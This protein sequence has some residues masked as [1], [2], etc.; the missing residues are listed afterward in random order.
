MS[1][2]DVFLRAK[3]NSG[4]EIRASALLLGPTS[5]RGVCGFLQRLGCGSC[6]QHQR[7][8]RIQGTAPGSSI[9]GPSCAF[10]PWPQSKG[11][12][13]HCWRASTKT[14]AHLCCYPSKICFTPNFA[15]PPSFVSTGDFRF[16]NTLD[17]EIPPKRSG[18]PAGR[19][20]R[21]EAGRGTAA[22]GAS[23]L[24]FFVRSAREGWAT[25][26]VWRPVLGPQCHEKWSKPRL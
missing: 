14:W 7:G 1:F 15:T 19:A 25:W 3:S 9:T 24:R 22:S 10:G 17:M 23:A 16:Q 12:H 26:A 11:S 21:K 2:L 4:P 18:S 8:V 13:A 20:A 5:L 6:Y